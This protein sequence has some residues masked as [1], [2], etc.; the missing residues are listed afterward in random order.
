MQFTFARQSACPASDNTVYSLIFNVL[1]F[2]GKFW[3]VVC[4]I[5]FQKIKTK[6]N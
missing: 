1:G 6:L 5:L 3:H 2:T 4:K